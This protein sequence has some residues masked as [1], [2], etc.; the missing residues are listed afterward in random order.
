M[1]ERVLFC[2]YSQV[3]APSDVISVQLSK[4]FFF[5]YIQQNNN[6][7]ILY[8]THS[9]GE[10]KNVGREDHSP[11]QCVT[12]CGCWKR[13]W[14]RRVVYIELQ[15]KQNGPAC[16]SLLN[17]PLLSFIWLSSSSFCTYV[18]YI[19]ASDWLSNGWPQMNF[20]PAPAPAP[21][22]QPPVFRPLSI[23][24]GYITFRTLNT[25]SL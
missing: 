10:K 11:L 13:S 2:V 20:S 16:F 12:R 7:F 15:Q 9:G 8:A 21:K 6:D 24:L 22:Q 18:V 23:S 5:F 3:T 25:R 17:W 4:S 19:K 14:I 1:L